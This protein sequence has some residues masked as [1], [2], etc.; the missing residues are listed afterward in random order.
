M[1]FQ[2]FPF[3]V[4]RNMVRVKV[5]RQNSLAG[6]EVY[7]GDGSDPARRHFADYKRHSIYESVDSG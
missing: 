4:R 2:Y 6:M 7:A 1:A 3:E 5:L